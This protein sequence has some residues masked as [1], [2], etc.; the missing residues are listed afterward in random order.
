[1][2]DSELFKL[3]DK[4]QRE[5]LNWWIGSGAKHCIEVATGVGKTRCA[6]LAT[7]WM[8][9]TFKAPKIL[10]ITPTEIIRDD[11]F[12]DEFTKWGLKK[13]LKHIEI[14][15]IQTAYKR[16]GEHFDLV[17]CDEAHNYTSDQYSLFF[18]NKI[19]KILAMTAEASNSE[20]RFAV[21]NAIFPICYKL[22]TDKAVELGLIS[23]YIEYNV[24]VSLSVSEQFR[25]K[26]IQDA[27][28]KYEALLGGNLQAYS[29]AQTFIK[30]LGH[31]EGLREQLNI[32]S[33]REAQITAKNYWK[34]MQ[35]RKKF[36]YECPSKVKAV[37][38]LIDTLKLNN[39]IIFSQSVKVADMIA[40]DRPDILPYH[41]KLSKSTERDF[42]MKAFLDGRTKVKHL[43]TCRCTEEGMDL[44]KLP[45]IIIASRNSSSKSH[46]QKRGR[47]LRYEEN[48]VSAVYNLYIPDTQD[49]K[50][51][52]AAQVKTQKKNIVWTSLQKLKEESQSR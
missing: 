25:Y 48:R 21:V 34:A 12:P 4:Y 3:K 24:A 14:Q 9:K 20:E 47:C 42:N 50:W 45:A 2:K 35:D 44:P 49:W 15:C 36:L 27:Y 37:Q 13:L 22:D 43:S 6:V 33:A 38:E 7:E 11:V 52:M 51:L 31:N 40:K 8:F 32:G 17:V 30:C 5:A 18:N 23:P 10:I 39:T 28:D 1:M 26:E 46:I 19:D 41:T 16:T 29:N